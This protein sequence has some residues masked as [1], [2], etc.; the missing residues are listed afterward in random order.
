MKQQRKE[1]ECQEYCLLD[2]VSM[3]VILFVIV[4][5]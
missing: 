4:R 1:D 3:S 2:T 5:N